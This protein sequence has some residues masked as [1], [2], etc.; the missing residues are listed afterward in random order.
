MLR[1]LGVCAL[2]LVIM[3]AAGVTAGS[4][5]TPA[6]VASASLTKHGELLRDFEGFLRQRFGRQPVFASNRY[7]FDC[8]GICAP[9]SRYAEYRYTFADATRTD[10]RLASKSVASMNFGN[11]P[12]PILVNHRGIECGAKNATFLVAYRSMISFTLACL[13]PLSR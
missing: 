11:Y 4:P 13:K 3:T 1:T 5:A 8:A 12:A 2:T 6:P 9:L 10:L 7:D